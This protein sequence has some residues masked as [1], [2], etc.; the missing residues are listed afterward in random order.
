[1]YYES[2]DSRFR[3]ALLHSGHVENVSRAR[4]IVNH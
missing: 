2:V 4:Y 1:M 3:A